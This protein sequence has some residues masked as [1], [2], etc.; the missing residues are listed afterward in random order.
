MMRKCTCDIPD[1]G[2]GKVEGGEAEEPGSSEYL[3]TGVKVKKRLGFSYALLIALLSFPIV[4]IAQDNAATQPAAQID[5]ARISAAIAKLGDSDPDVRDIA[6]ADLEEAADAALP[7]LEE[8]RK[9]DDPEIQRRA[10]LAIAA[11]TIP[12]TATLVSLD[13]DNTA[14]P[15]LLD[16]LARQ[17]GQ[18]IQ[19]NVRKPDRLDLIK[20]SIHVKNE[21]FWS[22]LLKICEPADLQPTG[23]ARGGQVL[24]IGDG[25]GAWDHKFVSIH[26]P[27]AMSLALTGRTSR[28]IYG[29]AVEQ[30]S[31]AS[32]SLYLQTEARSH[33][34]AVRNL[35]LTK[36][37]DDSGKPL[38]AVCGAGQPFNGTTITTGGIR[39]ASAPKAISVID[40]SVDYILEGRRL[41]VVV[42]DIMKANNVV[43]PV[44]N[45]TLKIRG[46][47]RIGE[48]TWA[49][50]VIISRG[51]RSDADWNELKLRI[52]DTRPHLED[53][54]G[55]QIPSSPYPQPKEMADGCEIEYH[56]TAAGPTPG[57]AVPTGEPVKL[58]W[59]IPIR[60]R[61][62]TVPFHFE[63]VPLP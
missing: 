15:A 44:G 29:K 42:L 57:Q 10:G 7:A 30:N 23:I 11:I 54:N 43:R 35:R 49:L 33:P 26:G 4:T 45:I 40:G 9:S 48:K 52:R 18:A 16:E 31:D 17:S 61:V 34:L 51:S 53:A 19:L 62:V 38:Q 2:L 41:H 37:L 27:F 28:V 25:Y 39:L 36:C 56:L 5:P 59:D 14:V 63:N 8:A 21:P 13:A 60:Q 6:Q 12:R 55:G 50:P 47:S 58:V 24:R 46:C 32:I 22:V 1:G 20:L 3:R